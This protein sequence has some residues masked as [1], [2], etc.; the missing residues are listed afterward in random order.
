MT[1]SHDNKQEDPTAVFNTC[2]DTRHRYKTAAAYT[3]R[4][5]QYSA[6]ALQRGA[7]ARVLMKRLEQPGL[8]GASESVLA[9][10]AQQSSARLHHNM[11]L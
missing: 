3:H 10:T 7:A 11:I 8:A 2:N 9:P 5:T 1:L 6:V 4:S